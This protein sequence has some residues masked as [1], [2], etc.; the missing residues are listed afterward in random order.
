M[1]YSRVKRS[2]HAVNELCS[3]KVTPYGFFIR[4]MN[5]L[6]NVLLCA[7]HT[8]TSTVTAAHS[9]ILCV[10]VVERQV[11]IPLTTNK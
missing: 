9:L 1:S 7:T 3:R 5:G 2:C 4:D 11:E 8:T 10:A 6:E